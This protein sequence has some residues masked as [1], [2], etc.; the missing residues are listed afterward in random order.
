M[1]DL[2]ERLRREAVNWSASCGDLFDEAATAL[3]DAQLVI[4]RTGNMGFVVRGE[5][6]SKV[7]GTAAA[8]FVP[9]TEDEANEQMDNGRNTGGGKMR[10]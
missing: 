9:R 4:E 8:P 6:I 5:P 10:R 2:I 3:E 7:F 1:S